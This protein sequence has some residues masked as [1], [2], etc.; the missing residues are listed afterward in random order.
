MGSERV[1]GVLETGRGL[2]VR[3]LL[4]R[5]GLPPRTHTLIQ[6]AVGVWRDLAREI[7]PDLVIPSN[8]AVARLLISE[9][10]E[11]YQSQ[12]GVE[13]DDLVVMLRRVLGRD[14]ARRRTRLCRPDAGSRLN[15][16]KAGCKGEG[17][18]PPRRL[19]GGKYSVGDVVS[20]STSALAVAFSSC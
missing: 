10:L 18:T 20:L 6:V 5:A 12:D 3:A 2:A 14:R 4:A 17:I 13:A 9:V 15:R 8:P 19:H 7:S 11:R 16:K 1:R